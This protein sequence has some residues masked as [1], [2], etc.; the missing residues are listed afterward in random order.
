MSDKVFV[1]TKAELKKALEEKT[2]EIL[3]TDQSLASHVKVVSYAS[4]AAIAAAVAGTGIAAL[5]L[6]NPIGWGVA[7]VTA[8]TSG[9]LVAAIVAL[10]VGATLIWVLW[11][12]DLAQQ[13]WTQFQALIRAS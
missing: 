4:K 6:W 12:D 8:I 9:T 5:N 11:N 2:K 10:G 7:G 3:I 13:P 1:S